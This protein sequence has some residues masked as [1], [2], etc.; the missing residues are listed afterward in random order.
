VPE[1]ADRLTA[2]LHW[3]RAWHHRFDQSGEPARAICRQS[4]IKLPGDL[5]Q[6]VRPTEQQ[7]GLSRP[8][9]PA[10]AGRIQGIRWTGR[11][12]SPGCRVILVDEVLATGRKGGCLD[13][14]TAARQGRAAGRAGFCPGCR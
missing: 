1:G 14:G 10:R 6:Q 12:K 9:R 3:R 13:T 11:R 4:R 8:S 2:P 7:V 5:L